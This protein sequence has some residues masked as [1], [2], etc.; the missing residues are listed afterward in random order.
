MPTS[1]CHPRHIPTRA[2]CCS[3]LIRARALASR[4]RLRRLLPCLQSLGLKVDASQVDEIMHR[5]DVDQSGTIDLVELSSL[6][7]TAQAR[8]SKGS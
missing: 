8:H 4:L 1:E 5:F 6:V 3:L 7:R 2:S